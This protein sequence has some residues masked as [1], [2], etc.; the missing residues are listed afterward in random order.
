MKV[1]YTNHNKQYNT[2]AEYHINFTVD[3]SRN[4]GIF[5]ENSNS[6]INRSGD[7]VLLTVGA[8]LLYRLEY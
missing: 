8:V 5:Q 6:S 7:R 1:S 2:L 3:K 4:S